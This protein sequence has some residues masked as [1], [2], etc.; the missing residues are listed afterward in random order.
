MI[1]IITIK[2]PISLG[3]DWTFIGVKKLLST[4]I[5]PIISLFF[6][7]LGLACVSRFKYKLEGSMRTPFKI[8]KIENK[9]YEHLTF[10]STYIIPLIAFDLS[11][12]KYAIVLL[13]L[14]VAI[15]AIYVKT[16]MFHANPSLALLGYHIYKADGNFRTGPKQDIIIISRQKISLNQR[17]SYKRL[18]EK[19]Y[20]VRVQNE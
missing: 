12:I 10:L 6:L 11:K 4:N 17:V 2:V 8:T 14:L 16:D 7:I 5:I 15:G 1:L 3:E 13:I 19:I 18:D 20:F 9:N